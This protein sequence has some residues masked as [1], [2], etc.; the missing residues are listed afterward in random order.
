MGHG[1]NWSSGKSK[2]VQRNAPKPQGNVDFS[3]NY[4]DV[5]DEQPKVEGRNSGNPTKCL[6]NPSMGFTGITQTQTVAKFTGGSQ[7]QSF[8]KN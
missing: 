8:I 2:F 7:S 3:V 6:A 5:S 4:M 1:G